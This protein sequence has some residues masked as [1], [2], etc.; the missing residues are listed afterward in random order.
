MKGRLQMNQDKLYDALHALEG[1]LTDV[2]NKLSDIRY[3]VGDLR[4]N[5]PEQRDAPAT[6]I[7]AATELEGDTCELCG[8]LTDSILQSRRGLV[9]ES[10]YEEYDDEKPQA[11]E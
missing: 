11:P 5:A 2:V 3:I 4:L 9:C 8:T 10:C 7:Q 6:S 1:S